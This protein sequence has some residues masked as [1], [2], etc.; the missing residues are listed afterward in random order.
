MA[1]ESLAS[2]RSLPDPEASRW[3][4]P[5]LFESTQAD[6]GAAL[7]VKTVDDLA[8][9]SRGRC[10]ARKIGFCLVID[11]RGH[12]VGIEDFPD[13]NY[14]W[15]PKAAPQA[16]APIDIDEKSE[17][18]WSNAG[19][20]LGGYKDGRQPAG[21]R[22][23]TLLFQRFRNFHEENLRQTTDSSL[24]AFLR[25]LQVWSPSDLEAWPEIAAR[26]DQ[27]LVFRFKYDDELLH[28][29]HCARL[30]W[31]KILSKTNGP[32]S[33]ARRSERSE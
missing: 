21:Y 6:G 8:D 4:R 15:V 2:S 19:K 13:P 17:F 29:R 18:L 11:A 32:A 31:K 12:V 23:A 1:R 28:E 3:S 24:L 22:L 9:V 14:L 30:I 10:K 25:F 26:L 7:S 33:T 5:M 20:A 16:E 27:N